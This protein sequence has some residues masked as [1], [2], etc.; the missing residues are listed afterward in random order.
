MDLIDALHS[1]SGK[2]SLADY[3]IKNRFGDMVSESSSS[4]IAL[5]LDEDERQDIIEAV[6]RATYNKTGDKAVQEL[7]AV[8][9]ALLDQLAM[10]YDANSSK[11]ED[12]EDDAE[13][14]NTQMELFRASLVGAR[15]WDLK[16]YYTPE[17]LKS[18][19]QETRALV[20]IELVNYSIENSKEPAYIWALLA[21]NNGQM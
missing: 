15:V 21:Q 19:K 4:D 17:R 11:E 13:A 5:I 14:T 20:A 9:L 8:I 7:S 1:V 2:S 10:S 18:M 12:N 16:H 3:I 6:T